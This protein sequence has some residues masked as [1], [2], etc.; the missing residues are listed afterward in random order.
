MLTIAQMRRR[1]R[2]T[3]MTT[4]VAVAVAVEAAPQMA[5]CSRSGR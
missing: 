4:M 3:T 1:R 5:I 2:R